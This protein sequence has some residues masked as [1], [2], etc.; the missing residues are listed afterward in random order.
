MHINRHPTCKYLSIVQDCN[1]P[2]MEE[3]DMNN[4]GAEASKAECIS[5]GKES[6]E[7]ERALMIICIEINMEIL[8]DNG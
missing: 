5:H 1:L 4:C 3:E 6:A 8:I 7:I 2:S